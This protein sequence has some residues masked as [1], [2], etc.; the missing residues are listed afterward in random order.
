MHTLRTLS[1]LTLNQSTSIQRIS[2]LFSIS[3]IVKLFGFFVLIRGT[4]ALYKLIKFIWRENISNPLADLPGPPSPNWLY[5]NMRQ[6]GNNDDS[7]MHERWTSEYG[8]TIKYKVLL[9]VSVLLVSLHTC[10]P[11]LP[12][13]R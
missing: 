7:V 3:V 2:S 6:I 8:N 4:S 10:Q 1:M 9:G 11:I 12:H 13:R 5:G